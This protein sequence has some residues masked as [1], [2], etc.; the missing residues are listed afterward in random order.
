MASDRTQNGGEILN[1]SLQLRQ[2]AARLSP[3]IM[4]RQTL[5]GF[6]RHVP[7]KLANEFREVLPARLPRMKVQALRHLS[8]KQPHNHDRHHGV[9]PIESGLQRKCKHD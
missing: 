5:P 4:V 2:F 6:L 8:F 3:G 9:T 1:T 7:S